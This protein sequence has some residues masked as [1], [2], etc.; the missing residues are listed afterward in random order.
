MAPKKYPVKLKLS[1]DFLATLPSFPT[2]A[3]KSRTKKVAEE[4]KLASSPVPSP[5]PSEDLP[6]TKA[7]AV[8]DSVSHASNNLNNLH[9]HSNLVRYEHPAKK[10]GRSTRQFKTFTGF[11]VSVKSWAHADSVETSIK[12]ESSSTV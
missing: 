11:K 6:K 1:L 5:G 10:W 2:P 8:K 9:L 7:T 12:T 3:P 4:V